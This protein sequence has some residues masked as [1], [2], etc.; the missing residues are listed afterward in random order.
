VLVK[1]EDREYH[2]YGTGKDRT[3]VSMKLPAEKTA[4]ETPDATKTP[5][6]G[7]TTTDPAKTG[8]S[9]VDTVK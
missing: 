9:L 1:R 8:A 3:V 5:T 4:T 2:I 6:T 7:T